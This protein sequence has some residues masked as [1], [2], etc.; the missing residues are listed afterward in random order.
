MITVQYPDTRFRMK[1]ENGK[2]FIFDSIRK[3]WLLLTEEEWVRQNFVNYIVSISKY[4]STVI[5]LEKEIWLNQLKKRFDILVY[6]RELRPWMMIEC[7]APSV[8]LSEDVL[9]QVLRYNISVPVEYIVIT[10][11]NITVGWKKEDKGLVLLKELPEWG[12]GL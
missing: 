4:P 9:Q 10:N 6:D 5:A 3:S 1:E 7:K 12:K 8:R 2:R 11:G